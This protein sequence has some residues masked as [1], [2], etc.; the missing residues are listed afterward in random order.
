MSPV[1]SIV[2]V[3]DNIPV[4]EELASPVNYLVDSESSSF[5]NSS[6]T[7]GLTQKI[8]GEFTLPSFAPYNSRS[9]VKYDTEE[10]KFY[11][12]LDTK[13]FKQLEYSLYYRHRIAQQLVPLIISNYGSVNIKFVFRPI[14]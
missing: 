11:S 3:S 2:V 9:I 10:L 14:S 12:L 6:T 8:I 5:V 4:L 7:I 13:L 1:Q